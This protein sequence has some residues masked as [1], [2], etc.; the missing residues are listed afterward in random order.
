MKEKWLYS[1]CPMKNA[2]DYAQ[3]SEREDGTV[4]VDQ[5]GFSVPRE[6]LTTIPAINNK[7]TAKK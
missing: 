3:V 2:Y 1:Y 4:F 5:K 7:R 6:R